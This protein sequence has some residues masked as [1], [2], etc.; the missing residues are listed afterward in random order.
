MDKQM[1]LRME[2]LVDRVAKMNLEQAVHTMIASLEEEGF[3]T[4]EIDEYINQEVQC[5]KDSL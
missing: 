5:S 2:G 4:Y 1:F 3:S